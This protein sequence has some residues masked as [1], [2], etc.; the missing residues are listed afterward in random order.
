[1]INDAPIT[2]RGI[3]EAQYASRNIRREVGKDLEV[4]VVSGLS[5]TIQ[6]YNW[7]FLHDEFGKPNSDYLHVPVVACPLGREIVSGADDLGSSPKRLKEK[8]GLP[9]DYSAL[10][11]VWW[12]THAEGDTEPE[13]SYQRY[14]Q[15]PFQE[16]PESYEPRILLWKKWLTLRPER[17]IAVICH[18]TITAK[19]IGRTLGNCELV[20]TLYDG[21]D[22]QILERDV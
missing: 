6:T 11:H 19:L 12:Y 15:N 18:R 3:R 5:R 21:E 20:T 14:K 10:T 9:I 13:Q 8:F 16:P 17:S 2:T 7:M 1:M 4:V 22:F